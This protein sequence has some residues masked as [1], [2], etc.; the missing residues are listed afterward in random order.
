MS[1][2][3]KFLEEKWI[4]KVFGFT[5]IVSEP[6]SKPDKNNGLYYVK[7]KCLCNTS[8][9]R[10]VRLND[11]VKGKLQK[12]LNC[13]VKLAHKNNSTCNRISRKDNENYYLYTRWNSIKN[14]CLNKNNKGYSDYG[15]R[16]IKCHESWIHDSLAFVNY[17]IDTLGHRPSKEFSLE[18]IDNNGN[19]EPNN[20]KWASII[21]QRNNQRNKI[22][23]F[24]FEEM[25]LNYQTKIQ[26]LKNELFLLEEENKK[27][28]QECQKN[29]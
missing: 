1:K 22:K 9:I 17:I 28:L 16:G 11:L 26:L 12:C 2:K 6:F 23:V 14:R 29:I 27:L 20:L 15:G 7:S 21:E 5:E 24:E 25:K 13:A 19:Y 18:R 8:D 10:D 4:G 3:S